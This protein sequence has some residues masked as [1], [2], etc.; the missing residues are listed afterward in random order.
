ML[1]NNRFEILPNVFLTVVQ[2]EKFKTGCCSINLLRPMAREEASA[3]ALIPSVLL[4]ASEKYPSIT[5]ISARLDEMYGA[6]VGTLVR[7]KGE[8][9]T[10]GLFAD[11]VED[12]LAGA[13]VFSDVVSFMGEILLR[14]LT[15]NGCFLQEIVESE[16]QNLSNAI[17]SRINDKRTYVCSQ[18]IR[19]MCENEI[20]GIPR[21]GELED[22]QKLD[23][24]K[25]YAHYRHILA[26]S[27][28]EIFY[29]GAQDA[30]TAGKCFADALKTL[31]R[32]ETAAVSTEVIRKASR[33]R[34]RQEALD[35]TQGKLAIG[36][37]TGC[38]VT[39]AEYPALLMLN[40]VFGAGITS[41]LFLKV[42]EEMSLCYYASSS[43]DKWKGVM[44][45]SSG[46]EFSMFD[47]AKTEILHQLDECRAGNISD[48]EFDSAK[49]Y[50]RS[51]LAAGM[52]NPSRMDDYY[53]GNI[54]A[55]N[56]ETMQTLSERIAAVTKQDVVA[57]ANRVT[58]DTVYFLKGETA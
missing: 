37:R 23:A 5:D 29:M 57:A 15:R 35:I 36:L 52:D 54:I 20:Y 22:V 48:C 46:I 30:K 55:G 18:M 58:L 33:V 6:S 50:I 9:Q 1:M 53:I 43:L 32:A 42:R 49:R 2:T 31:E 21:L 19:M 12:R 4:R 28:I 10:V 39:D 3:N 44:I 13:P 27:Q 25:L 40:A 47:T 11:F 38:T 24:Q 56:D 14:P 7:K 17:E 8:V 16:K 41:K 45:V 51:E 34:E 26:H